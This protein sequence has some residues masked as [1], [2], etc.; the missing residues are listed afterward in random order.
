MTL[1]N[2]LVVG[3]AKCG[4]TTIFNMLQQH[5]EVFLPAIKETYFLIGD[6]SILGNGKGFYE[7]S[8]VE[9]I[10]EYSTLFDGVEAFRHRAIGEVCNGYLY[11]YKQSIY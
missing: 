2:F 11:F 4:T 8:V 6:Q 1:P 10:N 5:P 3:A 9:S 7:N